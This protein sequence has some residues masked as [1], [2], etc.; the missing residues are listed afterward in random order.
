MSG[1]NINGAIVPYRKKQHS[2]KES[3]LGW[4][5]T[6]RSNPTAQHSGNKHK[7]FGRIIL[8]IRVGRKTKTPL[9]DFI[10]NV[11]YREEIRARPEGIDEYM[12]T[13][14]MVYGPVFCNEANGERFAGTWEGKE[15]QTDGEMIC[16]PVVE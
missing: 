9:V 10:S 7:G 3:N 16:G 4:T 13:Y 14:D 6:H 8:G 12:L 2:L 15:Q 11:T 1:W 5:E